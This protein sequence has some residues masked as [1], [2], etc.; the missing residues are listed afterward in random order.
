MQG[1]PTTNRSAPGVALESA[2]VHI[3]QSKLLLRRAAAASPGE[4]Q[5]R[6][7]HDLS[8]I[9]QFVLEKVASIAR[10]ETE[11]GIP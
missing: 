6:A 10:A 7:L 2:L 9:V 3:G 1:Q 5:V 4:P 8:S 11:R